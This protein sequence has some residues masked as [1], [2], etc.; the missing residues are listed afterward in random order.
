MAANRR[1]TLAG[2]SCRSP[3]I[4][5]GTKTPSA[6]ALLMPKSNKTAKM[7]RTDLDAV[8]SAW[9]QEAPD[10]AERVKRDSS[11]FLAY[12]DENDLVADFQALRYTFITN[13]ANSGVHPKVAQLLACHSTITLTMDRDTHRLWEQLSDALERLPD[14]SSPFA[15]APRATGTDGRIDR[16]ESVACC[17]AS[18]DTQSRVSVQ[19]GAVKT[20]GHAGLR[21]CE[22]GAE[23]RKNRHNQSGWGGIRTP[24]TLARRAVFK[25]AAFDHS[26]THP[27]RTIAEKRQLP[28]TE[29]L[30]LTRPNCQ[31]R[32]SPAPGRS[33]QRTCRRPQTP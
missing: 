33:P 10:A 22:I 28:R 4:A 8:C 18:K 6:R 23:T 3:S 30:T 15:C 11:I 7:L 21:D 29:T 27:R 13:L 5:F 1:S 20:S 26:A 24:A 14:F 17:V 31:T 16:P 12:R 2:R 9:I 32:P 19:S 25:T